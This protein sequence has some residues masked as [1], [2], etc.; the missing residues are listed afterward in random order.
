VVEAVT[1]RDD[2]ESQMR[3]RLPELLGES[4]FSDDADLVQAHLGALSATHEELHEQL[5]FFVKDI[6]EERERGNIGGMLA[7]MKQAGVIIVSHNAVTYLELQ[8]SDHLHRLRGDRVVDETFLQ[9]AAAR[10]QDE[11]KEEPEDG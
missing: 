2:W 6:E 5:D 3:E 10:M 4:Y 1:E 7:S 8:V 9:E 11:T